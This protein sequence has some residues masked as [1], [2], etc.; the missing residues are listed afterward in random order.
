M[1]AILSSGL[2]GDS[3]VRDVVWKVDLCGDLR[4]L[5]VVGKERRLVDAV[6]L[7]EAM[8]DGP[9]SESVP[10]AT[11]PEEAFR[12]FL[13]V[14][15]RDVDARLAGYLDARV[16]ESARHGSD[17]EVMTRAVRDLTLRGGKRLRAALVLV[18]YLASDSSIPYGPALDAGVAFELLQTYLI[19]HDDWMDGDDRRRGGPSVPAMLR[20]HYGSARLGDASAILAGDLASALSLD[21]LSRL[22]SPPER[23]ISALNLFA[24]IQQDVILGQQMDISGREMDVELCY[25][26]KT[27]SYTVRGPLLLGA[28]LAGAP[29][30]VMRALDEYARP[31]GVAFQMQDDILGLY[32]ETA[33]TGKPVGEDIRRGSRTVLA[34]HAFNLLSERDIAF[35]ETVFGNPE[36]TEDQIAAVANLLTVAGVRASVVERISELIQEAVSALEDEPIDLLSRTMLLGFCS[37]L[38]SRID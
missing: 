4:S 3:L 17:V 30:D 27:G 32:G 23:L 29:S 16:A 12:E 11:R 14:V 25:P 2:V 21:V 35:F 19:V 10:S 9:F 20:E 33:K 15:R 22:D 5:F 24:E 6:H 18:G 28:I 31:L 7:R 34:Q 8:N 26:L 37:I 38:A 36:A 13:G 1:A